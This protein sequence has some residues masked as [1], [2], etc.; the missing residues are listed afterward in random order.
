[1]A[2]HY[3]M[4]I[5]KKFN[6]M[7]LTEQE[8]VLVHKISILNTQTDAYRRMLAKVRGGTKAEL[9][10]IDDRPDLIDLKK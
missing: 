1:M 2:I 9:I 3:S 4:K 5:T 6:K 7:T 8:A 10:E